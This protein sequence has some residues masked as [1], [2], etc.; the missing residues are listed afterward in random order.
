M[1]SK[2]QPDG[3]EISELRHA[4]TGVGRV[5]VGA[6]QESLAAMEWHHRVRKGRSCVTLV[7][8]LLVLATAAAGETPLPEVAPVVQS[9][10]P[11][12]AQRGY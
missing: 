4:G 8:L 5:P 11:A 7:I 9:V 3:L 6:A 2:S 10:M 1:K 12:G